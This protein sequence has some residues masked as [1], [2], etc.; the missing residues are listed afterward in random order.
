MLVEEEASG[1]MRGGNGGQK[2]QLDDDEAVCTST[3]ALFVTRSVSV[4]TWCIVNRG[5][6]G[7]GSGI[8][9]SGKVP[10]Q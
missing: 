7:G 2:F 4:R 10:C 1:A 3:E 8:H 6:R 5:K 9:T